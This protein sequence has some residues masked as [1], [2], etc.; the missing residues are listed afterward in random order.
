M[1][2]Y[3]TRTW[4][5]AVVAV[6]LTCVPHAASALRVEKDAPRVSSDDDTGRPLDRILDFQMERMSKDLKLTDEQAAA[7]APRVRRLAEAQ[8]DARRKRTD[9]LRQLEEDTNAGA[10]AKV[11]EDLDRIR[12]HDE[13]TERRMEDLQK[14]ISGQLS[15]NQQARYVLFR[16]KFQRELKEVIGE[17]RSRRD[18]KGEPDGTRPRRQKAR[19]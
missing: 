6:T 7:V 9:L 1:R 13:R 4:S 8:V 15:P 5:A 16:D 14:D 3:F 12:E 2:V 11:R 17:A 10:E 18:R 19:P